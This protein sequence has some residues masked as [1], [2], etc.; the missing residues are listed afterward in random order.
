MENND[1]NEIIDKIKTGEIK[2]KSKWGFLA[3]KVG[4]GTG[5]LLIMSVLALLISA[6]F[7]YAESNEITPELRYEPAVWREFLSSLPYGLMLIIFVILVLLCYVIGK[8]DFSYE[9]PF[10]LV[11]LLFAVLIILGALVVF[12]TGFHGFVDKNL[13][14]SD[15]DIPFISD[16]YTNKCGCNNC[17]I[18]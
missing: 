4:L 16:F 2:M 18:K 15:F 3:Q 6:F 9:K 13:S 17:A 10:V 11:F 1:K 8:F 5:L 12:F 7:Y 14:E